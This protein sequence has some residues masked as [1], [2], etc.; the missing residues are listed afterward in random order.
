MASIEKSYKNKFDRATNNK[1][2][3]LNEMRN[4]G[5]E[6]SPAKSQDGTLNISKAAEKRL[7]EIQEHEDIQQ[8]LVELD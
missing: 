8:K 3:V 6:G 5:F 2:K 7:A 1:E 4:T